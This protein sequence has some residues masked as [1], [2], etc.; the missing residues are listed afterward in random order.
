M[1]DVSGKQPS[2]RQAEA[3][4]FVAMS[5]RVLRALPRNPKG[6]PLEVARFACNQKKFDDRIEHEYS[7]QRHLARLGCPV[8]VS[9]GDLE[10]PEFQRQGREFAD[11]V[12]RAGKLERRIVGPCY[13]H[14]EIVETLAN[15][16]GLL[17]RAA[18]DLMRL[19]RPARRAR[20]PVG[21]KRG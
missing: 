15:P 16:Y 17:G 4:A 2:K 6:N 3:S 1:V 21:M 5:K 10:S 13:N 9:Y 8:I 11:A 20:A 19:P 18:L 7:S 14:F 12:E